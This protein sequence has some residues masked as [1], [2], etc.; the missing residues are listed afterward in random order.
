MLELNQDLS[1]F[2]RNAVRRGSQSDYPVYQFSLSLQHIPS[3]DWRSQLRLI[4]VVNLLLNSRVM[5]AYMSAPWKH[6][7]IKDIEEHS[8]G[9]NKYCFCTQHS[10][11]PVSI[12]KAILKHGWQIDQGTTIVDTIPPQFLHK[13][14]FR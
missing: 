2:S 9:S 5:G 6:S 14:T 13:V 10:R 1:P 7:L 8:M 3:S 12:D 4:F 11:L